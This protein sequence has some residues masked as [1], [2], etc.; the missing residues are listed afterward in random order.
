M[1]KKRNEVSLA[2]NAKNGTRGQNGTRNGTRGQVNC[3]GNLVE[4]G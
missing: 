2:Y 3:P 4:C 1:V